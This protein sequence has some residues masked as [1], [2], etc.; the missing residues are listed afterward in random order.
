MNPGATIEPG[1]SISI[2]AIGLLGVDLADRGDAPVAHAARRRRPPARRCRRRRCRRAARPDRSRRHPAAGDSARIVVGERGRCRLGAVP[3]KKSGFW[4]R[5]SRA[6]FSNT[7]SRKSCSVSTPLRTRPWASATT[8]PISWHVPV[9]EVA[10]EHRAQAWRRTGCRARRRRRWC[11]RR[12]RSRSRSCRRSFRRAR[13]WSPTS[14]KRHSSRSSGGVPA[15]GQGAHRRGEVDVAGGVEQVRAVAG[16]V[17][18]ELGPV[19]RRRVERLDRPSTLRFSQC[20]SRSQQQDRRP[21][22]AALEEAR[23]CS[24]REAVG[25]AAH[26]QRLAQR[27]HALGERADVVERVVADRRERARRHVAEAAVE[28]GREA[29]L[30]GLGPHRVVVVGAVEAERV[31]PVRLAGEQERRRVVRAAAS[32]SGG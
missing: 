18:V 21:A 1:Q 23:S 22:D 7:N 2:A 19:D 14:M 25:D 9:A 5:S 12:P 26:E 31:E 32:G 8:L 20:S 28:H 3:T 16:E 6:G 27:V 15:A 10:G 4:R 17:A 24:V 11:G 13:A 30:L 29:E